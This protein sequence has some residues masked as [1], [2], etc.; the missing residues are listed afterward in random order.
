MTPW[1]NE[2]RELAN[3]LRCIPLEDVLR[4]TG[5]QR[6]R[7]D[8]AKWHTSRGTLSLTGAKFMNWN[9][10]VGGGGAIDLVM[11]LE[12]LAFRD[13][14]DWLADRFPGVAHRA[15]DRPIT[16]QRARQRKL[17]LPPADARN[18]ARI[19]RYL[20]VQRCIPLHLIAPLIRA[21]T[22]YSD[23]R[24]NA[25]FLLLGKDNSPV[26]AEIRGTTS[27]PWRS[28]AT[29]SCKDL[30]YFLVPLPNKQRPRPI[31]LCES[32]I[33]ALSCVALHPH[34]ASLSTT[35]ARANPRWLGPLLHS[36]ST[37]YCGFDADL[38]GD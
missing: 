8:K 4:L 12:P 5:A 36:S 27:Q 3:Q 31:V 19:R 9:R 34:C 15:L 6:D 35:G 26:G 16:A 22:L 32:A 17:V 20:T 13:A 37:I 29:G 38:T 30:G 24:G 10:G 14:L 2:V 28:M 25:V 11:H 33:D 21:G 18:L 7:H 1:R 23:S